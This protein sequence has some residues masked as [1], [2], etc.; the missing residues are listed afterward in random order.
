MT[1]THPNAPGHAATATEDGWEC[2]CGAGNRWEDG[3]RPR[4]RATGGARRHLT[5]AARNNPA[6][7][8]Q[9]PMPD[10]ASQDPD[11]ERPEPVSLVNQFRSPPRPDAS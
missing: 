10:M 4:T 11:P 8:P 5:A 2:S 7:T 9:A 3:P 1:L 6:E